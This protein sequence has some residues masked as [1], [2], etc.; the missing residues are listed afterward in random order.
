[1]QKLREFQQSQ[2]SKELQII[3]NTKCHV[4]CWAAIE[5]TLKIRK[6]TAYDNIFGGSQVLN[7]CGETRMQVCLKPKHRLCVPHPLPQYSYMSADKTTLPRTV[8]GC[9]TDSLQCHL[10]AKVRKCWLTHRIFLGK[11]A[12]ITVGLDWAPGC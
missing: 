8:A 12:F 2:I 11:T 4:V 6:L 10:T 1:M 5:P 9:F 7:S 3:N